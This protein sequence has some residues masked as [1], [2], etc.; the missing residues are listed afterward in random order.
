[1]CNQ[2]MSLHFAEHLRGCSEQEMR[3]ELFST[4]KRSWV[5]WARPT[6]QAPLLP[7]IV[8]LP[9][10]LSFLSSQTA[11][12]EGSGTFL[13]MAYL[14]P[15]QTRLHLKFGIFLYTLRNASSRLPSLTPKA[16]SDSPG[17]F[18]TPIFLLL[19]CLLHLSE[20]PRL[21]WGAQVSF[22][23]FS[24]GALGYSK[25]LRVPQKQLLAITWTTVL[26]YLDLVT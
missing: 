6:L 24:R 10:H 26:T 18:N 12:T 8:L 16:R 7:H 17:V 11:P 9:L 13:F 25:I 3:F 5:H 23:K 2:I 22:S 4:V 19:L 14:S 15:P 21:H 1:M 20:L